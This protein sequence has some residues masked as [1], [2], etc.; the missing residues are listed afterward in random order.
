MPTT[1]APTRRASPQTEITQDVPAASEG[2]LLIS[3]LLGI[4]EQYLDS[5][6]VKAIYEAYLF[7]A[8]AHDG[9]VRHSGEAYIFHPLSVARILADIRLDSRSIMAALLHDVIEDTPTAKG[10][11]STRFGKDVAQLVD[12]VSK[13]DQIEF[14][15]RE[16]AEAENFRKMLLAMAQDIRVI[17]I[18]LADRIHNMRTL[19]A[20]K[21]DKRKRIATQTLDIF[22]PIANRLGM[23]MWTQELEDLSFCNLYPK[24]YNTIRKELD[25]RRGN[26][27][28]IIEKTT[29]KIESEL[30]EVGLEGAVEGREKN[31][32]SVYRKMRSRRV[33]MSEMRDIF[34]I[35]V[36]VR[37]VDDCYRALGVI[38]NT[39]KPVPGKFKDYIA[40]PK[41]NGYQS[42]HTLLF[43]TFGQ[44]IEVQIRSTDMHRTAETGVASHWR[45]KTGKGKSGAPMP[46]HH[47]LMD[48]LDTQKQA[49][50]PSEFLEHLKVDLYPDEVY[51]FTPHGDIKKLPKGSSALDFAYAVHSDVGNHCIGARVNNEPVPLHHTVSNGDHVEALTARSAIP[52]PLWLNYVVTAK[53]R[54]AIRD[55]LKHQQEGDASKLGRQLLERAL[56]ALGLTTRLRTDQKI[57]LLKH[58]GLEDWNEL[59]TDIGMGRRL[60]MIVARQLL[61]DSSGPISHEEPL[62]IRGV[63]GM[64]VSYARCCR[65]IPGDSIVGLFS[66]GRGIV[67]HRPI[68]PNAR[69]QSKRPDTW[70]GVEW[71]TELKTTF[72]ADIRLE[73]INRRG[74]FAALASVI[75]EEDSNINH[76][77]VTARDDRNSAIRFTIEVSDR[78]HLARIIRRLRA[79]RSV[80]RVSRSRG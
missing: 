54:A 45:Y 53:A 46:A 65:P 50:N 78:K 11:L 69:E 1:P 33:P 22:A 25:K 42:L 52:T 28:A 10:E 63:E 62:P 19:G 20:L 3:D 5:Q 51:V 2:R 15:S 37:T 16:H 17:L 12:G 32:Y 59:L 34:A 67:I 4:V 49:G 80:I 13:I 44:S 77:L 48:L 71:S 57:Q 76:V 27:R 36:I 14:E 30:E 74:V 31:I 75:A 64:S 9:Q 47:W 72:E 40:I 7:G 43:G 73:V 41:A 56:K 58:I 38:H 26:H 29:A 8:E 6:E 68:C 35:R 39:Y 79:R 23:R 21:A 70:V 60:P 55:F 24:R 66:R 18:K 61:P